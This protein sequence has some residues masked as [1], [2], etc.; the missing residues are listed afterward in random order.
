MCTHF[1][2]H[3]SICSQCSNYAWA[4]VNHPGNVFFD[5]SGHLCVHP[6]RHNYIISNFCIIQ[7]WCSC[8][9]SSQLP[10]LRSDILQTL[11]ALWAGPGAGRVYLRGTELAQATSTSRVVAQVCPVPVA[12]TAGEGLAALELQQDITI[13]ALQCPALSDPRYSLLLQLLL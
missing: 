4:P 12:T 3:F 7:G 13:T 9:H 6:I 11:L 10:K 5:Y 1:V 2:D 8:M